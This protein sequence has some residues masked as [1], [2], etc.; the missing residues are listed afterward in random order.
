MTIEQKIKKLIVE[1][2]GSMTAFSKEVGIA[3]STLSTI[4]SRGINKAGINN[5]FKICKA[6]DISADALATG[7]IQKQEEKE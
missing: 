7:E 6:L 2:Y 3:N 1:K 5:I 4:L